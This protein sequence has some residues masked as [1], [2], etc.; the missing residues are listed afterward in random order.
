[1]SSNHNWTTLHE[2][3]TS[4]KKL[5]RARFWKCDCA[6]CLSIRIDVTRLYVNMESNLESLRANSPESFEMDLD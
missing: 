6:V 4:L 2:L 5:S 1:M 3:R